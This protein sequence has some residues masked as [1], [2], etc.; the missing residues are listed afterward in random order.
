MISGIKRIR[1]LNKYTDAIP[2]DSQ[3]LIDI[4]Y[5]TRF[6][7]SLLKAGFPKALS[8]GISILPLSIGRYSDFNA[9][10]REII[11][12]DREKETVTHQRWWRRKDWGGY[13]HEGAIDYDVERHPREFVPPPDIELVIG[14]TDE[15]KIIY[16]GPF[17]KN[18]ESEEIILHTINLYL[19]L[20]GECDFVTK[21]LELMRAPSIVRMNWSVLP[22]GEYPW[23]VSKNV[24][25]NVI[26]M[27]S[28]YPEI[29]RDRFKAISQHVPDFI[30][31]GNGG[32]TGYVVFGFKRKE[33]FVL[34]SIFINDAT[35]IFEKNWQQL[36]QYTKAEILRG[37]HQN[38][39]FGHKKG[40]HGSIGEILSKRVQ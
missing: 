12:R 25:E 5:D 16:S 38:Y 34:D 17:T 31:T 21:D 14:G 36:S 30:A 27:A 24:L 35:Y 29:V 4:K 15:A 11:R 1:S 26:Q 40:W 10:G 23:E 32:F 7:G 39:Q 18:R 33:L 37:D 9:F 2:D 13:E 22:E 6:D 28:T 19:E 3:F 8:L 20:F